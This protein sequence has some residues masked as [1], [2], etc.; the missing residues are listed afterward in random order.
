M[1]KHT[2]DLQSIKTSSSLLLKT[3]FSD[4]T[5]KPWSAH[6][7]SKDISI[8]SNPL[9]LNKKAIK[10]TLMLKTIFQML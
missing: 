10:F 7:L 4:G 2:Y 6:G 3:D 9:N 8:V 1:P 5:Y